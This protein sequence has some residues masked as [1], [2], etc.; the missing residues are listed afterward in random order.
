MSYMM[1]PGICQTESNLIFTEQVE[2]TVKILYRHFP[3]L[4]QKRTIK[5]ILS[6]IEQGKVA[7]LLKEVRKIVKTPKFKKRIAGILDDMIVY[8]Q[9][10]TNLDAL[11]T[12]YLAHSSPDFIAILTEV[13]G[14]ANDLAKLSDCK[15]IRARLTTLHAM[16]YAHIKY[17]EKFLKRERR[18]K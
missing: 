12:C 18:S 16:S 8:A 10:N 17:A 15:P 13:L 1:R 4:E 5:K 6:A 14:L 7:S 2:N 3:E 11:L 9:D